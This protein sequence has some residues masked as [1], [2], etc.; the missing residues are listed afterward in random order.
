M[1]SRE[2]R[3]ACGIPNAQ[4]VGPV[5]NNDR[6]CGRFAVHDG[7]SDRGK[8]VGREACL[9]RR[10]RIDGKDHRRTAGRVIDSVLDIDHGFL[11]V[12]LDPPQSIGYA[13]RPRGKG[14]RVRRKE[15]DYYGFGSAGEIGNHVLE[16]LRKLD[17]QCRLLG[18]HLA[19]D[20]TDNI[21]NP[22]AAF[23]LQLD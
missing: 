2:A 5:V 8:L 22:T 20:L 7:G 17:V 3:F 23:V 12:D 14:I 6:R 10:K 9:R 16:N 13:G 15:F 21:V 18:R 19:A 1:A 11:V 4:G